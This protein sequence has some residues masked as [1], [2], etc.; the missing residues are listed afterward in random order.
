[1]GLAQVFSPFTVSAAPLSAARTQP[2]IPYLSL[3]RDELRR[4]PPVRPAAGLR[5]L[6]PSQR[7]IDRMTCMSAL[8][9]CKGA[10]RSPPGSSEWS[11]SRKLASDAA[12]SSCAP[13]GVAAC[14][15]N[16]QGSS[17][18]LLRASPSLGRSTRGL[19]WA[20]KTMAD[21]NADNS[22]N[23][24]R[25]FTAIQS[26]WNKLSG[27]LKKLRRGFPVK[28]LFF[29]IGFYCATAFATVI[30]QTGDWDILSAGLAVAIV[31]FIGALMYRASFAFFGRIKNMIT[32]FNYWK[33]G[34]T[35]G[36]F[37]DSFKYEVDEFLESCNP[38]NFEINIFTRL[39]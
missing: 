2:T 23:S 36:L 20:I 32:I 27:K 1:M 31:E 38:F 37:L 17:S 7:L 26:F 29:L 11:G 35:L 3:R 21:D 13:R 18:A 16:K 4:L 33:A 9:L 15:W 24:T 30:G 12:S 39:W 19:R 34:L 22:G 14:R 28:I 8:R 10:V 25:L 6:S 5:A